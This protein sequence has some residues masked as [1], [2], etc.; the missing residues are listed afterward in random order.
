MRRRDLAQAEIGERLPKYVQYA[1]RYWVHHLKHSLALASNPDADREHN[2]ED[3]YDENTDL[4]YTFLREH[5]LHW[6]EAL[7]LIGYLSECVSLIDTLCLVFDKSKISDL[8]LFLHDAKRL[9]LQNW[10]IIN[11]APLQ[12]YSSV[13]IFAPQTSIVRDIFQ[14]DL[15]KWICKFPETPK[16]WGGLLQRLEGHDG[17]VLRVVFSPDG[18]QLA[19]C[20]RESKIR[21]W[22]VET[23]EQIKTLEDIDCSAIYGIA[24]SPSGKYLASSSRFMVKLWDVVLGQHLKSFRGHDLFVMDIAFSPDGKWLTSASEDNEIRLWDTDMVIGRGAV[25]GGQQVGATEHEIEAAMVLQGHEDSVLAIAYSRDGILA[26]GSDDGTVRLWD[27]TTGKQTQLFEWRTGV[28]KAVAFSP[29]GKQIASVASVGGGEVWVWAVATGQRV[30]ALSREDW[31]G[32]PKALAF[33]PDGGALV[34]AL[35]DGT[36][37]LY[38][39][40]TWQEIKVLGKHS[41]AVNAVAFSPDGKLIASASDDYTIGLWDAV[42]EQRMSVVERPVSEQSMEPKTTEQR[43]GALEGRPTMW[44]WD[45]TAVTKIAFSSD[46]G[47]LA[48]GSRDGDIILWDV[49]TGQPLRHFKAP[50]YTPTSKR[51]EEIKEIAF[52][53]GNGQSARLLASASGDGTVS[54]WD[55][56]TGKLISMEVL[57]LGPKNRYFSAIALSPDAKRLAAAFRGRY[58][59]ATSSIELYDVAKGAGRILIG[60]YPISTPGMAFSPDGEYL[61]IAPWEKHVYSRDVREGLKNNA[62]TPIT[63]WEV[64]TGRES[65]RLEPQTSNSRHIGFSSDGRYL[66]TDREI[67]AIPPNPPPSQLGPRKPRIH[68]TGADEEWITVNDQDFLWLPPDYRGEVSASGGEFLAIANKTGAINLFEFTD[69]LQ[70]GPSYI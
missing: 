20:G 1:C 3:I 35:D 9:I 2:H 60:R 28:V 27:P 61:A 46:C 42:R 6:L 26:S 21:F 36:I 65:H 16:F 33:S 50:G 25:G 7:S 45:P 11:E 39:A 44:W 40:K 58:D 34:L 13:L 4:I 67:L 64:A 70:R 12:A 55:V 66:E 32:R 29:D 41:W 38:N 37:E 31:S 30:Q 43:L 68:V 59:F 48:S 10:Q 63:V 14:K 5:F 24:F 17:E 57:A 23:G 51:I 8:P 19:S 52:L 47:K 49:A 53:P 18:K 62:K 56:T 69:E 15:P 54:M 22:S